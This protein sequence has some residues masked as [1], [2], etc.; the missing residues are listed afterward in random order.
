MLTKIVY[1]FGGKRTDGNGKQKDLLGGKGANLAEMAR[2]GLPVPPGFTITTEVCSE[3]YAKNKQYPSMLRT[4]V[5]RAL[6]QVEQV[7]GSY[8]GDSENPLLLSCRSGARVSMPGMMDTVLNIG[9]NDYTIQGLIAKTGNPRFAYDSYRRF[10]SMYGD[11]V[12]GVKAQTETEEDPFDVILA[13][14]KKDKGYISD[15]E[16]TEEDLKR[17][18]QLYKD[19][20]YD[21][22]RVRFPEEPHAQLWGAIGAVFDSWMI[23]RAIAYRQRYHYPEDW[24]TAVN[25]QAMVF[26][27]MGNNSATGVCFSRDPSTGEDYFY[28][29]FLTNAQGEDVVAGIRTPVPINHESGK[30]PEGTLVLADEMP[31]LYQEL[32]EYRK[33]LEDHYRD[34]QDMEFT[35]QEGKLWMLQCRN[36]KRTAKAAIKIAMDMIREG[37][38]GPDEAVLRIQPELLTQLLLPSF[39]QNEPSYKS[40]TILARGLAASP[41][42]AVGRVCFSASAAEKL[43]SEKDEDGKPNKVILVRIETSPEDIKGMFAAQGILTARGGMTSHA[44]VV[45]R[46]MGR[47]CV[48]GSSDISVDY[49]GGFFVNKNGETIYAGDWISLDGTLGEIM[50][51]AFKT[52]SYEPDEDFFQF[53]DYVDEFKKIA[54]RTNADTPRDATIAK[55]YGAEGIGLCRT[56]HMFFEEDRIF[57]VRKMILSD[58]QEGRKEALDELL[59]MQRKDFYEIFKA[60]EGL[61]VTIRTLDPPLHEFLPN[62]DHEVQE[63]ADRLKMPFQKVRNRIDMLKEQNPMLGLR[64]CRLGILY[65]EITTMQVRAIFEAAVQAKSEGL[66]V[67]PEIMIPLVGHEKEFII[68]KEIVDSVAQKIFEEKGKSVDY[69]VGTMIELPRA[70]LQADL[71]VEAGAEFFSFGT[72]DLTQTTFGLSR[73]DS[74]SF[75]NRYSELHIWEEDPFVTLDQDGVGQLVTI[76]VIKGRSVDPYLKIGICGEH[77]GDPDSVFFCCE[78]DF[79]YVSCSPPRVPV[80]RLAAAQYVLMMSAKPKARRAAAR[81]KPA[82]RKA[83]ARTTTRKAA[84]SRSSGTRSTARKPAARKAA[85]SR[86]AGT[87]STARK[88]AARRTAA[89]KPATRRTTTTRTATRKPATRRTTTTRSTARK[90]AARRTTTTRT[91]TRKPAARRTTTTRATTR[92]PAARRTTT[93]RA[94]TRKPAARRTTTT[95]ATSRKPAARR[96]T[97]R[98]RR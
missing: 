46:G 79:N 23:P 43:A 63:L 93:T 97:T 2:I 49:E 30:A 35:I 39:D 90:P 92:K 40:R 11:V 1:S 81:K 16:L 55:R 41:G 54:V 24:G 89:R 86:S 21:R 82:A 83:A 36:G 50:K 33:I 32:T 18:V 67:L 4:Q 98:G 14:L 77:G 13:Q 28:G 73:D 80:A 56:E 42:A 78:K 6:A 17:L 25:V 75:L 71:I 72:N 22:Q 38:I 44:A 19:L 58:N 74:G 45:A 96:T 68:Q 20:I 95:R 37:L 51:G 85:S 8:F 66:K 34:M 94:T 53:M 7:V 64:G 5:D 48:A 84:S 69:L 26:G 29:E 57:H 88:P 76:G 47:P 60:L 12:M 10:V 9:L 61:P 27:N 3:Y 59:P 87:R 91:A 70:A 62:P 65:P 52:T 15:T 31:T